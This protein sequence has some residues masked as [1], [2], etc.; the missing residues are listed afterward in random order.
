MSRPLRIEYAHAFYHITSRGNARGK[1][2]LNEKD[3]KTFL[4]IFSDAIK[5]YNWICYSYCLM[6]NHYHLLIE[7]PDANLSQGMRQLNGVYTQKFNYFH[8]RVGHIFQGRFKAIL[9][10][11]ESYIG[12]LVRYITLNPVR[13]KLVKTPSQWKWSGHAEI[14]GKTKPTGCVDIKRA[15]KIFSHNSNQAK[16]NYIDFINEKFTGNLWDE[17]K[18]GVL[19]GTMEFAEKMSIHLRKNIQSKEIPRRE[20]W[21]HRPKLTDIF[22]EEGMDKAKRNK[23]IYRAYVDYGYSLSEIGRQLGL[24]YSAISKVIKKQDHNA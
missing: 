16:K 5:R 24:H 9:A 12:E 15:L 19:L 13:A 22:K 23:L 11:K 18:G 8:H 14:I 21:A 6:P 4:T 10:E 20:R 7:T 2:F 1:I 17:L 3:Y